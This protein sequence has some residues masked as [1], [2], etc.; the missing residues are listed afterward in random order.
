MAVFL[1]FFAFTSALFY[2]PHQMGQ[3][4]ERE[5]EKP[6]SRLVKDILS[7]IEQQPDFSSWNGEGK[8]EITEILSK[9]EDH[10]RTFLTDKD[11]TPFIEFIDSDPE[12]S[13]FLTKRRFPIPHRSLKDKDSIISYMRKKL[14]EK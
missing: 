1:Y 6:V 9:T 14:E 4:K 8:G 13:L 10:F 7:Q 2:N 11:E 3:E 12:I 5:P